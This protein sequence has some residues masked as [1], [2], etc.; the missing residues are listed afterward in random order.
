MNWTLGVQNQ[1][2]IDN[3]MKPEARWPNAGSSFPWQDSTLAH[4]TNNELGD[5]SYA[6]AAGYDANGENGWISDLQLPSRSD[7]YWNG[8]TMLIMY[9]YGWYIREIDH[10]TPTSNACPQPM[11]DANSIKFTSWNHRWPDEKSAIVGLRREFA[12]DM[13]SGDSF[14]WFEFF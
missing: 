8:A 14:W 9:G 3:V 10:L 12:L 1:I 6:N 2:F 13:I 4:P 11:N 5:W 7:D